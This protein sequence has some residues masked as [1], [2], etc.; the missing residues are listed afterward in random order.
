MSART[1]LFYAG[2]RKCGA[3]RGKLDFNLKEILT[4]T[5][6]FAYLKNP[7]VCVIILSRNKSDRCNYYLVEL[8]PPS[9]INPFCRK[10]PK[11]F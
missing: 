7:G 1:K 5:E 11:Q 10:I 2:G 4:F 8:Q 9:S 6:G 3:V